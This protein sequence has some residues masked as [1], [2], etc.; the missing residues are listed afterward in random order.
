MNNFLWQTRLL[1]KTYFHQTEQE[2]DLN[3]W[4]QTFIIV[5][6]SRNTSFEYT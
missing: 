6:L 5:K 3:Q 4:G 1:T 2:E